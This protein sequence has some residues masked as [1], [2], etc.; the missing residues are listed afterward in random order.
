MLFRVSRLGAALSG[1]PLCTTG[2]VGILHYRAPSMPSPVEHTGTAPAHLRPLL[3]LLLAARANTRQADFMEP[4]E[5]PLQNIGG[6]GGGEDAVGRPAVPAREASSDAP[7][8]TRTRRSARR[9][10]SVSKT[11]GP[12]PYRSRSLATPLPAAFPPPPRGRVVIANDGDGD[13]E[14]S[15]G[16]SLEIDQ[17]RVSAQGLDVGQELELSVPSH[18]EHLTADGQ[19]CARDVAALLKVL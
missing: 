17:S 19:R 1:L 2:G 15:N 16:T 8:P 18:Q 11:A 5:E 7:S 9:T 10:S 13:E 3:S 14:P 4:E 12:P 6:N